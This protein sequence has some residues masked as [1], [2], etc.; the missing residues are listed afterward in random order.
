MNIGGGNEVLDCC[1]TYGLEGFPMDWY[2]RGKRRP[3]D[4]EDYYWGEPDEK[5]DSS[6]A[7]VKVVKKQVRRHIER[8]YE[9]NKSLI[10]A[11]V[12]SE[13]ALS[14]QALDELGFISSGW[15]RR[16]RYKEGDT[17]VKIFFKEVRKP[18]VNKPNV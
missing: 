8:A 9:S 2:V 7:L 4:G 6:E 11:T 17:K 12:N 15:A 14:A 5:F 10:V 16:G 3:R 1:A 13:Q 18:R